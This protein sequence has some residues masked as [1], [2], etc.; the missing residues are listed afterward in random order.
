MSQPD[1]RTRSAGDASIDDAAYERLYAQSVREP[2]AF[3]ARVAER[4]DWIAPMRA[5]ASIATTAS[6]II[7]R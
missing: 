4:L 3:W 5:Q 1:Q 2:D 7:G 6:G